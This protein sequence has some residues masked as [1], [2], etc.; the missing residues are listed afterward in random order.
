MQVVL[1]L[2]L[3]LCYTRYYACNE[4][5]YGFTGCIL[6]LPCFYSQYYTCCYGFEGYIW[7]VAMLIPSV[8]MVLQ[9]I[10]YF[11]L[12]FLQVGSDPDPALSRRAGV[13][14]L[15]PGTTRW[16]WQQ[17]ALPGR[18]PAGQGEQHPPGYLLLRG[19][20]LHQH[21]HQPLHTVHLQLQ[22][23]TICNVISIKRVS[24]PLTVRGGVGW[25]TTLPSLPGLDQP[26]GR[27]WV[28]TTLPSLPGLDPSWRRGWVDYQPT[29]PPPQTGQY[30][31]DSRLDPP[32]GR[33]W[34]GHHPCLPP[35]GQSHSDHTLD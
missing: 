16:P 23:S 13:D 12:W 27:G 11:L 17:H 21:L 9:V 14:A 18:P 26:R 19:G 28:V 7:H 25:I 35:C 6:V 10:L 20:Q 22:V 4:R 33:G 3:W 1:H 32:G 29:L 30:R 24:L 8:A 31:P 2:L 34:V 15:H 5:N